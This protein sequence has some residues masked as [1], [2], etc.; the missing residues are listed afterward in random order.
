MVIMIFFIEIHFQRNLFCN[1]LEDI[2]VELY[3]KQNYER[4][5]AR[6]NVSNQVQ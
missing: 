2:W 1:F 4:C 6:Y 5:S 3:K